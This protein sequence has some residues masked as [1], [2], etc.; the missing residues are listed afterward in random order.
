VGL[1]AAYSR[2]NKRGALFAHQQDRWWLV[3]SVKIKPGRTNNTGPTILDPA[4]I[5]VIKVVRTL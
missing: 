2:E 4:T 5:N 1:Q 3:Y